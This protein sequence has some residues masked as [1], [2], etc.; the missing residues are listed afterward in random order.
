[1][2]RA[3]SSEGH[4]EDVMQ[5]ERQPF[6]G[7]ERLEHDQQREPDR[8]R[9]QRFVRGVD[10]T[11]RRDDRIGH[12][13]INRLFAS[14]GAGAQRVETDPGHHGGQPR[15]Q[16]VHPAGVCAAERSSIEFRAGHFWGLAKVTGHFD[17]YE[18]QLDLSANPAVELT[19]D[20]NSVQ[21][22]NRKRDQHLHSSDHREL[23]MT[24]SPLPMIPP[25]SEL[26][27]KA[28]LTPHT[29]MAAGFPAPR[30]RY[31]VW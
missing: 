11:D 24:W 6:G 4:V 26:R 14:G 21:T 25:R 19:I 8:V 17:T 13:G 28:R 12:V 20:A 1:M 7:S 15:A 5:D 27:I 31:K 23:G 2:I 30:R 3:I 16:I 10:G 18:A 29:N 9:D 22:G